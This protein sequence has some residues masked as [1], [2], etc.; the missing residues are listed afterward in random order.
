MT[1][2]L[3]GAEGAAVGM[4]RYTDGTY[5]ALP[6]CKDAVAC[7]SRAEANG[8][9]WEISAPLPPDRPKPAPVEK[10]RVAVYRGGSPMT[11]EQT[12]RRVLRTPDAEAVLDALPWL[13]RVSEDVADIYYRLESALGHPGDAERMANDIYGTFGVVKRLAENMDIIGPALTPERAA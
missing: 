8:D 1:C 10:P 11:P 3:C 6:R 12:L 13:A 5:A 7:R 2:L 9:R 4:A